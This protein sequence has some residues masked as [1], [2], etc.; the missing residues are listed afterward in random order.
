MARGTSLHL[1][2]C[3]GKNVTPEMRRGIGGKDS[4]RDDSVSAARETLSTWPDV[5]PKWTGT[6]PQPWMAPTARFCRCTA[7]TYRDP[8]G[9]QQ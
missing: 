3:K 4:G 9:G 8:A 5:Q 2:H 6:I 1:V 7:V